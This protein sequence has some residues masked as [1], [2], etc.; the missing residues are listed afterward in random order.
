MGRVSHEIKTEDTIIKRKVGGHFF[1]I[2][3]ERPK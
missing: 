2:Y 1:L 3:R